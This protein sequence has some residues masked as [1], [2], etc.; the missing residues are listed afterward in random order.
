MIGNESWVSLVP[1]GELRQMISEALG[2]GQ[3]AYASGLSGMLHTPVAEADLPM[4]RTLL[5][6][7]GYLPADDHVEC[8]RDR[9]GACD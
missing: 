4:Y 3:Y 7:E 2:R 1:R 8:Q 6:A 9:T 5:R